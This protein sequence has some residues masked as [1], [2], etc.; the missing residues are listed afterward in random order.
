[1]KGYLLMNIMPVIVALSCVCINRSVG[2]K[3]DLCPTVKDK[4]QMGFLYF[5]CFSVN[6]F[7]ILLLMLAEEAWLK[8]HWNIVK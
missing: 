3:E 7:L 8:L 6:L 4:L 1:M 5:M 2:R